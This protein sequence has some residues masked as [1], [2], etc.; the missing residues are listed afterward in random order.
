MPVWRSGSSVGHI[1][2]V[3]L[4]CTPSSISTGIGDLWRVYDSGIYLPRPLSLAIPLWV[5]AV[6][7]LGRNG[8]FCVAVGLLP[9]YQDC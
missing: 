1:N 9:T 3:K 4:Q 6:S 7:T 8:E 2:K 5:G